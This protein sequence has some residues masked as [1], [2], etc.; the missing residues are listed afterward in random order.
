MFVMVLVGA[1]SL[2]VMFVM[3]LHGSD[4]C[5]G[6]AGFA[7]SLQGLGRR[8]SDGGA[9]IHLFSH[10]LQRQVYSQ[11]GSAESHQNAV[12]PSKTLCSMVLPVN[13]D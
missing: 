10:N 7:G 1:G 5:D 3:V 8:A 12:S 9:N 13:F 11:P 4:V 2:S 6:F